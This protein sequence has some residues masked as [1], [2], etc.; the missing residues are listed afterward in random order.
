[1]SRLTDI[2]PLAQLVRRIDRAS[3]GIAAPDTVPTGF[4]S[5]D[6]ALGGGMRRGD[7]VVLGGDIASGKSALA[8]A[9][10]QRVA[11]GGRSAALLTGEMSEERVLERAIAIESRLRVDDLRRGAISETDRASVRAAAVHMR[12]HPVSVE[13]MPS[14]EAGGSI[15]SAVAERLVDLRP[16]IA[17][18]D[19]LQAMAMAGARRD[20]SLADA[21][22]TLKRVAIAAGIVVLVVAQLPSLSLRPDMRPVLDDFGAL[23]AVKESADIVL[24]LYRE[25]MYDGGSSARGATELLTLKNRNGATEYVDLFFYPECVRFEDLVEA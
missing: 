7:L 9:I 16:A 3:E 5:V 10:A 14:A 4:P 18:V 8:L 6:D 13:C 23:G 21:V 2:S 20:E 12:E 15:A 25:E 24:G 17:V 11:R 1:M 22:L 19:S